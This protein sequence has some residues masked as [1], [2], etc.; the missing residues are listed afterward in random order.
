[1]F[2]LKCFEPGWRT[3]RFSRW[4]KE[5]DWQQF[6]S[7]GY[8]VIRDVIPI[9]LTT[10]AALD[11]AAFVGA[12]IRDSTTWYHGLV[13]N[14]GMIPLHHAQSLWNIRQHPRLHQVFSEYLME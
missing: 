14:D 6:K 12:D 11:I 3:P 10:E 7:D 9:C 4:I 5:E 8:M 13:E 2:A 1:M